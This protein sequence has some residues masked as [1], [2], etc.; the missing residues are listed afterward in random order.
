MGTGQP[1]SGL[2]ESACGDGPARR[3]RNLDEVRANERRRLRTRLRTEVLPG[4]EQLAD[5]AREAA[6]LIALAGAEA[7]CLRA[8]LEVPAPRGGI[9]C[10]GADEQ[11]ACEEEREWVRGH[12]H[13]TALQILD[14]IAGDGF[15]TGL[16][17]SKI[18]Q[19][20]GGA[21]RD[22]RRWT[23]AGDR[24][25]AQLVPELEEVTAQARVL[26]PSVRLVVGELGP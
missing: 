2:G 26:D 1:V 10:L 5:P 11:R 4:L 8:A 18:A 25:V 6:E 7:R 23:D 17:A 14:F 9:V 13:D 16:D 12:V 19:L 3:P 22:L 15:G 21:A 20:A 24:P